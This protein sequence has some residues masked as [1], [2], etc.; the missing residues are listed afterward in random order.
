MIA[1]YSA[2]L[3]AVLFV[4]SLALM[5]AAPLG[6]RLR[7]WSAVTALTKVV[8][9]GVVLAALAVLG[10]VVSLVTGGWE[11][12]PG[13]TVMLAAI[14]VIGGG[15]VLLPLRAKAVA[16]KAPIRDITT[17][18]ADPPALRALLPQRQAEGADGAYPG[19]ATAAIQHANY[20][21]LVPLRLDMPPAEAFARALASAKAMGWTIVA[22][23]AALGRIEAYDKTLWFGFTD[24]VVIRLTPEAG[25]TRADLR[26]VSR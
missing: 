5:L 25:G 9:L 16:E 1:A 7:L 11:V 19:A 2:H 22:E 4:L 10:A 12:G 26:S 17:D 6:Y 24:D 13:T 23:D 21:D 3:A 15:A 14:I 8:A 18:V 20:P